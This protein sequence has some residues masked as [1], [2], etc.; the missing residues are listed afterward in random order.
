MHILICILKVG[1]YNK[2]RFT[3]IVFSLNPVMLG[4]KSQFGQGQLGPKTYLLC[5]NLAV[6]L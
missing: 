2:F 1:I 6:K 3:D 5:I 4:L